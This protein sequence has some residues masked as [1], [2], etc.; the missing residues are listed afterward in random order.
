MTDEQR[1]QTGWIGVPKWEVILGW[2][3]SLLEHNQRAGPAWRCFSMRQVTV[4]MVCLIPALLT[5]GCETS[6]SYSTAKLTEAQMAESIHPDTQAPWESASTFA[7][8]AEAIYAVAKLTYAPDDTRIKASFHYLENGNREIADDEIEAGG[9]SWVS[10]KLSPP[11]QGWPSGQYEARFFLNG[12]EVERVPFNV[13]PAT[14][15]ASP[16]T[17]AAVEPPPAAPPASRETAPPPRQPQR[18]EEPAAPSTPPSREA[19]TKLFSDEKFGFELEVPGSWSYRVTPE[20]DYLIEGPQGTDAFELYI[21]LQFI[22]KTANPGSSIVDQAKGILNDVLQ[23]PDAELRSQ[24]MLSIAGQD[25]PYFVATYTAKDSNEQS[26]M[27]GHRQI[28]L[29]HGDYYYHVSYFGPVDVYEKYVPVFE[30]IVETFTFT[31]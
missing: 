4:L 8:D 12:E 18:P 10:F 29:D 14:A 11:D 31:E 28:V 19:Q 1:R 27:F 3:L 7:P 25:A 9:E 17:T 30:H 26:T 15:Q 6:C 22:T 21:V 2:A 20:K 13:A 23:I 24:E 16:A 5:M